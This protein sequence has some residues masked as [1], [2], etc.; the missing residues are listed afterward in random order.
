MPTPTS[1][2]RVCPYK[3]PPGTRCPHCASWMRPPDREPQPKR[4]GSPVIP[5][6]L[7]AVLA[8]ALIIGLVVGAV[9]LFGTVAP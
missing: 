1:S 8:W 7:L 6:A 3:H 5:V 9:A 4:R 2:G